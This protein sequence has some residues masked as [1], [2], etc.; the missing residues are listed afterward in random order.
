[1]RPQPQE[2][3]GADGKTAFVPSIVFMC[4]AWLLL[5]WGLF[6]M[7][8][9]GIDAAEPSVCVLVVLMVSAWAFIP[10]QVVR[11]FRERRPKN[12]G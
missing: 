6:S 12:H 5:T 8:A 11:Y 7:W 4:L 9:R 2:A 10:I 1:M 3:S